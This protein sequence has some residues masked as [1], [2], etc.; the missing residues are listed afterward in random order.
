MVDVS[1]HAGRPLDC[2]GD[3]GLTPQPGQE[4]V[5]QRPVPGARRR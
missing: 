3:V 1:L 4:A 2:A 5:G